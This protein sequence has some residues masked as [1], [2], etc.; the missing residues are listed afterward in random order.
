MGAQ[1]GAPMIEKWGRQ[2]RW[3]VR[4]RKQG[5]R[6]PG[7]SGASSAKMSGAAA[8]TCVQQLGFWNPSG[9]CRGCAARFNQRQLRTCRLIN[10][11]PWQCVGHKYILGAL[12]QGLPHSYTF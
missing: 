10:Q 8:R 4:L 11:G 3:P 9:R 7:S 2:R 1:A 12:A 5:L 6:S